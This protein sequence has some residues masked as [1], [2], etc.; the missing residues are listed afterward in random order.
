[1]M[2]NRNSKTRVGIV[3]LGCPRNQLDSEVMA[4]SIK[5]SGFTIVDAADSADVCVINTCAFIQSA[6]EESVEKILE[7]IELKK[8][9]KIGRLVGCGCLPQ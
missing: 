3:S 5:E 2:I 9:G 6:R 1:M 8:R 4:G 7:A